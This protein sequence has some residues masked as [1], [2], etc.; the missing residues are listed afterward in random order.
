MKEAQPIDSYCVFIPRNGVVSPLIFIE[1]F[2]AAVLVSRIEVPFKTDPFQV[3]NFAKAVN[4]NPP[5]PSLY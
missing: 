1:P 2:V 3:A 5:S 4:L